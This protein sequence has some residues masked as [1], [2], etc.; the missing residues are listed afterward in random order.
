MRN[1]IERIDSVYTGCCDDGIDALVG[2]YR[3]HSYICEMTV[4]VVA[5]VLL[6]AMTPFLFSLG[7]CVRF[8]RRVRKC[9]T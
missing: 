2:L 1:W 6:A 5:M 7:L 4:I 9:L 3:R 8:N